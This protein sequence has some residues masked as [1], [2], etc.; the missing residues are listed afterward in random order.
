MDQILVFPV[1]ELAVSGGNLG[2]GILFE[3]RNLYRK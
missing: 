1:E 2:I 3:K